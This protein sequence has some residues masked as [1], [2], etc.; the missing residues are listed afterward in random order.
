MKRVLLTLLVIMVTATIG[1]A[2]PDLG[3]TNNAT[4]SSPDIM[5]EVNQAIERANAALGVFKRRAY[6]ALVYIDA[7]STALAAEDTGYENFDP[8]Y[9]MERLYGLTAGL[10]L[11]LALDELD[12]VILGTGMERLDLYTLAES[13]DLL[14]A[15][16]MELQQHMIA[17]STSDVAQEPQPLHVTIHNYIVIP[18]DPPGEC[19]ERPVR[20][21][22]GRRAA[23]Q[24]PEE[25]PAIAI[26]PDPPP[27]PPPFPAQPP[28]PPPPSLS[29]PLVGYLPPVRMDDIVIIPGLPNPHSDRVYRIQVGAYSGLGGASL[30]VRQVEAAG[31]IAVQETHGGLFRVFVEGIPSWN[32]QASVQRL[33]ALGF[34]HMWIRE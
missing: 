14:N 5:A 33:A 3:N 22:I 23:A 11:D 2:Q 20:Q 27:E 19:R 8:Q 24:V 28:G 25:I 29:P 17:L 4:S 7:V 1:M 6:E 26:Q 30:A 10:G 18:D 13:L 16:V 31:F 32:V 15:L 9:F 34:T 12:E 21:N